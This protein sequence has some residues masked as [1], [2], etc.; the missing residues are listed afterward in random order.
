MIKR[1]S[2]FLFGTLRGR[3]ILSVAIV[4]AM[5]MTLFLADLTVRQR[6]LL[7]DRQID[8]ATALSQT[9]ATSSAGWIAADDIAG[10]QELVDA[11]QQYP[12]ILFA[13]IVD[14][15][16]KVMASF[17]KSKLGQFMLDLPDEAHQTVLSS[18]PALVDVITPAVVGAYQ[19]GW[20]RIGIGQKVA[21]EKMREIT[22]NGIL[23]A[24]TAIIIGSVIAWFMG[25]QISERLYA[26]QGT[27]DAIR[28]GNQQARSLIGGTDE[29]AI[30]AREFNSMLDELEER[31]TDL[32]VSE[33]RYRSLIQKVQ[34]AI[35]VHNGQGQILTSNTFAQELLGLSDDQLL[36]K[37]LIDPDWHFIRE[38]GSVLPVSEYPVSLVLS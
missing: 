15:E 11:Q 31:N 24:F 36:G 9:L 27:I 25:R 33:E 16:G 13:I 28:S 3:L 19:V 30:L 32:H 2:R 38:D 8:E 18:S 12:E 22:R 7:L 23:Y 34:T 20:V 10:L 21:S 26:V 17:D 5:M 4:H 1:L 29:A 14:K 37:A 35:V 6:D